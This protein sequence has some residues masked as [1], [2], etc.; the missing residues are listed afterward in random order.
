MYKNRML[1]N[2][3]HK[4]CKLQITDVNYFIKERFFSNYFACEF[5]KNIS[6][7]IKHTCS[8]YFFSL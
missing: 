3:K 5:I 8:K 1:T 7:R 6:L 2:R 4:F